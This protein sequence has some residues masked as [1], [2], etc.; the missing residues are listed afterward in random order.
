MRCVLIQVHIA[1]LQVTVVICMVSGS[2]INF[3]VLTRILIG[4]HPKTG[5]ALIANRTKRV[6][7]FSGFQ[8]SST[9]DFKIVMEV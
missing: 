9:A 1:G 3:D 4:S 2:G 8:A 5:N 6:F 7:R